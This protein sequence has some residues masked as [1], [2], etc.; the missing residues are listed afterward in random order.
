MSARSR[1]ARIETMKM[2]L[3]DISL[4][5]FPARAA[6]AAVSERRRLFWN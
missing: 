4:V 6:T 1:D 3:K 5:I 2:M